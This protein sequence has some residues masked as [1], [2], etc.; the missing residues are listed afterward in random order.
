MQKI[1][2]VVNVPEGSSEKEFIQ[3]VVQEAR[4]R[5][6]EVWRRSH[7]YVRNKGGRPSLEKRVYKACEKT[8]KE[9]GGKFPRYTSTAGSLVQKVASILDA[10]ARTGKAG[11]ARPKRK[12]LRTIEK[13]VRLWIASGDVERAPDSWLRKPDGR[14]VV[15]SQ[16]TMAAI[17]LILQCKD[18]PFLVEEIKQAL[19]YPTDKQLVDSLITN[20]KT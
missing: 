3:A 20:R 16:A 2:I 14:K 18:N 7:E 5:A 9:W 10:E 13:Y 1:S 8:W 15:R 4:R 11:R 17:S 6:R 19:V 12:D